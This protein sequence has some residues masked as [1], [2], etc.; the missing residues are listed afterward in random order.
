MLYND[1]WQGLDFWC[2]LQYITVIGKSPI[3]VNRRMDAKME[4][5]NAMIPISA[6]PKVP[7][8]TSVD[9]TGMFEQ[10]L[11]RV[12]ITEGT[13]RTYRYGVRDFVSW[14]R[15]G[16]LDI[17][18]LVQ[19]KNYLRDRTDLTTG[20]KNLYLSGVRTVIKTLHTMGILDRDT[21]N[22]LKGF[23]ITRGHK[24][25]PITDEEVTKVFK[26]VREMSDR[27]LLL[28]YTLLYFQGLRQKEC[29]GLQVEDFEPDTKSLWILGKGRD[30][31]ERIDLHP[32]TGRVLD[33]YIKES[34]TKSG[35]LFW[36]RQNKT[37]HMTSRNLSNMITKVH[38]KCGIKNKGHSWRKV[39][40][41]KLIESG[42]DLLTVSSF[43]RHQS[44]EMLKVYFDR[45]DRNKKLPQYYEVFSEQ[46]TTD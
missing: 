32:Q 46:M 14:N 44:I 34:G 35:Y 25:G 11:E 33:W 41:S 37:G 23:K 38:E 5:T 19:Y 30:D 10:V 42:M 21:G 9:L 6:V 1:L 40:V 43:S 15:A 36:S 2:E 39:F 24:K 7:V 17:T 3:F 26:L 12:D 31:R 45:L 20:T 27:R 18:T 16:V 4:S 22:G 29:L 28:L 13:R 8:E